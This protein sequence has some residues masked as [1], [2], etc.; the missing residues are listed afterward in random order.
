LLLLLVVV[1]LHLGLLVLLRLRYQK[2][3]QALAGSKSGHPSAKVAAHPP[4]CGRG[5]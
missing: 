4:E 1:L 2:L 3:P 5:V